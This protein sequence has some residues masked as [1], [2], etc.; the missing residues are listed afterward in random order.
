[1]R[2]LITRMLPTFALFLV[3]VASV[4]QAAPSAQERFGSLE[5]LSAY[6]PKDTMLYAATRT[7]ANVIASLDRLVQ[8]VASQL[9]AGTIP[10]GFPTTL[11]TALDLFIKQQAGGG[12]F[13][14]TVQPWLGD[15]LAVGIYPAIRSA[16]G[17]IVIKITDP[18]AAQQAVLKT[19]RG[20]SSR[21]ADGYTLLSNS[22]DRNQIA[23]YPDVMV[24]YSWS[25]DVGPQQTPAVMPNVTANTYY[26]TALARL[27]D[28]N[29]DMIAFVDT[30]LM[31]A[32]NQRQSYHD[33][34]WIVPAAV[35]RTLGSTGL[36]V[37]IGI[38]Q[39]LTLDAV[40]TLGNTVGLDALGVQFTGQG[41]ALN[42]DILQR[43]PQKAVFV[44]QA[45]DI[46]AMVEFAG[47]SAQSASKKFQTVLPS[48]ITGLA[49]SSSVST[50]G[51]FSSAFGGIINT[52]WAN[53]LFA[54]LSGYDYASEIR[55]LLSGNSAF[56]LTLNPSYNPNSPTFVNRE[57]FDGAL[58][59]EASDAQAAQQFVRKLQRE[60]AIDIYSSGDQNA[61]RIQEAVLPTGAVGMS[62]AVYGETG[63]PFDQFTAAA[64]DK[65]LVIGTASAVKQVLSGDGLGFDTTSSALLPNAGAAFYMNLPSAQ[66]PQWTTFMRSDPGNTA[67]QFLPY[68]VQ[69]LAVSAAGTDKNDVLLRL[70][71]TLPCGDNCG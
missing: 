68:F 47:N 5:S 17:R 4:V 36:G 16:G 48:I 63:Q 69:D 70:K 59:F 61:V 10:A 22:N 28:S 6:F 24:I 31:L 35:Y 46:G 50:A 33:G 58:L 11:T 23:I 41:A 18:K 67:L 14:D 57:P 21:D 66:S 27:P 65:W 64:Q 3:L 7:D 43:V 34:D 19:L 62:L 2:R 56:F 49:Y 15:T 12:T 26:T 42:P 29:Y 20:W 51:I 52:D 45:A 37:H 9:P 71:L 1:M 32:Y 53:V 8:T 40:Q 30:P 25:D 54:N 13:A 39:T 55:P 60:L 44:M 38:D